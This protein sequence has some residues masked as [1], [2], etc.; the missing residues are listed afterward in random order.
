M[1]EKMKEQ[2]KLVIVGICVAFLIVVAVGI[3]IGAGSGQRKLSGFLDLGQKYLEDMAYEDA[4][5]VFDEAIAIDPKCAEAYLG[6]AQAQYALGQLDAAVTTLQEGIAQVDD[7]TELEFF[8]QQILDEIAEAEAAAEAAAV[9][10]AR[11]EAPLLLNYSQIVRKTDTEDPE[12]QLEVLGGK[13]PENYTWESTNEA[14]AA[15]SAMG[16]VT[17]QPVE[18]HAIITVSNEYGKSD[19]CAIYIDSSEWGT[20]YENVRYE[21]EGGNLA[22]DEFLSASASEDGMSITLGYSVLSGWVYYSGDVVIPEHLVYKGQSRP[23]TSIDGRA[24][25]DGEELTSLSIP[26]TVSEIASG[27]SGCLNLEKIEVA[28][29]NPSYKSVDG[30]LFSKDGKELLAYPASRLGDSYTVPK[31]VETIAWGAFMGCK[32]LKEILVEDGN[33]N[34]R[35]LD[36]VL[37]TK[38]DDG[39]DQLLAYPIGNKAVKYVVPDSVTGLEQDAFYRSTLEEVVCKTVANIDSGAFFECDNLH[40]LEGGSATKYIHLFERNM[41][42]I[43]GVEEMNNLESL[44]IGVYH[45]EENQTANL[46]KLGQLKSLKSLE[47]RGIEDSAG[48]V[49]LKELENLEALYLNDVEIDTEDLSILQNLSDLNSLGIGIIKNLSDISWIEGI[50]NLS[51]LS[52]EV[53]D[54]GVEDFSNLLE[55]PNLRY[56]NIGSYTHHEELEEQ[57]EKMQE[58]STDRFFSYYEYEDYE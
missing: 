39:G 35:S 16:L 18:G 38:G 24:F 29:G 45:G 21:M 25:M 15:V 6:K 20:E 54:I 48:L 9:E 33:P 56:V 42:E 22:D 43:A 13:S 1:M 57:F 36:G 30:V 27:F 40:R 47:I 52:L 7:A 10:A 31:E 4:I 19:S 26:A 5:L 8:L 28:A 49:W 44:T 32:N 58:E 2:K 3:Y 34:Y 12:I 51:S 46:Q 41:V 17:C 37:V 11:A 55:M 23:V 50:S 14:C 53:D